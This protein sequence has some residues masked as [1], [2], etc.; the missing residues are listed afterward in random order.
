VEE[1]RP[2]EGRGMISEVN[3][4]VVGLDDKMKGS[5]GKVNVPELK[6]TTEENGEYGRASSTVSTL[7]LLRLDLF[8]EDVPFEP[9]TMPFWM[10]YPFVSILKGPDSCPGMSL[11]TGA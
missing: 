2:I 8:I 10:A 5:R 11:K 9:L 4:L 6:G 7:D 3:T 1:R